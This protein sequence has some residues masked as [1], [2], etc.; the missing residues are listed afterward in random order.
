MKTKPLLS[1]ALLAGGVVLVAACTGDAPEASEDSALTMLE[2][3]C[4]D[5]YGAEVCSWAEVD[6][7]RVVSIGATIPMASIE[8]APADA[9]MVWPPLVASTLALP[10]AARE[11]L[12]VYDLK[13]Y[14]EAHGHPP[15]PYLV[16]HFD[17]HFY[18]IDADETN[19]IDCSDT[20]KPA[21]PPEGYALPDVDIPEIGFLPGLCVPEMGMHALLQSE[22]ESEDAFSAAMV[23]GYYEQDPIFYEPMITRDLLMQ[24]QTFSL[25]MPVVSG[26][27][28]GVVMPASFVAEFDAASDAYRFVFTELGGG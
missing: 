25:D 16:P 26:L 18:T 13:I 20:N 28:E 1:V 8:G 3:E 23:I 24:R 19:A 12:G 11:Q 22:L 5:V 9:E 2:G 15:G 4:G 14:W 21:S 17:F 6:G 27:A 10:A 7:E